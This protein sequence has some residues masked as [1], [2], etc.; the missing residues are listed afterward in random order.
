MW[1]YEWVEFDTSAIDSEYWTLVRLSLKNVK[2]ILSL[3]V[4]IVKNNTDENL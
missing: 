4:T 3:N 1:T 2:I